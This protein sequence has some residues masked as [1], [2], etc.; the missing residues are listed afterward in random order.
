VEAILLI[1]FGRHAA[2]SPRFIKH[3]LH[4]FD[5]AH[6][7]LRGVRWGPLQPSE[8]LRYC[9]DEKC[10]KTGHFLLLCNLFNDAV[11]NSDF[12]ASDDWVIVSE[13]ESI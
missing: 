8:R 7:V 1:R 10:E 2:L 9:R 3:G 13:L 5:S 4:P 11:N 6:A 12:I